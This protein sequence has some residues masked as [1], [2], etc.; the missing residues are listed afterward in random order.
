MNNAV[1][2]IP[3][4]LASTRLPGKLLLADTG[5]PLIQH[6]VEAAV[7]SKRAREV[8]VATEDEEI[9]QAVR[10][11][12]SRVCITA[13]F[14]TGTDR[15]AAAV[16]ELEGVEIVVNVQGDEPEIEADSIDRAIELLERDSTAVMSTLATPI[17]QQSRL[18]DPS[19]V[20]VV[21]DSLGRALL[22]SR[23]PIPYCRDATRNWLESVPPV[24]YQHVGLYAYRYDFLGQLTRMPRSNLER[25]ESL[26]QMRV[27]EGGFTIRVGVVAAAP[28]GIDTAEDYRAFVSRCSNC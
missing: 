28:K 23:S 15:V 9:A 19:C 2:V 4:R 26:E 5:K 17:R 18:D 27:L 21:I 24:F 10:D 7:K 22:F 3:A 11:F 20:K 12:G 6:T 14:D 16:E 13:R 1:I 8:I 25:I